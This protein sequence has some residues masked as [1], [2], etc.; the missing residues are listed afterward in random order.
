MFN[1]PFPT[2]PEEM[3][4]SSLADM[5]RL[6]QRPY[7]E[8]GVPMFLVTEDLT[9]DLTQ[10]KRGADA[11]GRVLALLL[12]DAAQALKVRRPDLTAKDIARLVETLADRHFLGL[13]APAF[14]QS[15][16]L[17]PEAQ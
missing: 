14:S 8:I 3:V 2:I 9:A 16:D 11:S 10:P 6:G 1:F 17:H 4:E 12:A 13:A 7:A 15:A 5:E